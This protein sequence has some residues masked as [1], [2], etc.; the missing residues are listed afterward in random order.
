M[1]ISIDE[2]KGKER[3]TVPMVAQYYIEGPDGDLIK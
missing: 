1:V 2:K 3:L